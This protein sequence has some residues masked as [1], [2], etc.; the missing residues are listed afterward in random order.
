MDKYHRLAHGLPWLP[1]EQPSQAVRDRVESRLEQL[2]WRGDY[3]FSH[4][5][6][7]GYIPQHALLPGIDQSQ[8]DRSTET[9]LG[10][11]EGRLD[12]TC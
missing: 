3:V 1:D 12:Y 9:W 11:I 10:E 7:P 2:G 6:P 8:V 4:T 5:V